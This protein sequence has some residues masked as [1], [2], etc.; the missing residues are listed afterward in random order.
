MNTNNNHL[1]KG[2]TMFT[3]LSH[4]KPRSIE[5]PSYEMAS[6]REFYYFPEAF[7]ITDSLE[8]LNALYSERDMVVNWPQSLQWRSVA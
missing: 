8:A 3:A 5:I 6:S 7:L 4:H 2:K 1:K